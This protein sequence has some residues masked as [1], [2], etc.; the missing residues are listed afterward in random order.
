M[1]SSFVDLFDQKRLVL[2]SGTGPECVNYAGSIFF[3][4]R[5][6]CDDIVNI[7]VTS[8]YIIDKLLNIKQV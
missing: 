4:S 2:Q 6:Q 5:I 8:G 7:A 3:A 1:S